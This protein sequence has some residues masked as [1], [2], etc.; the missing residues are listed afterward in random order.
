MIK[1]WSV[2]IIPSGGGAFFIGK[3]YFAK[4]LTLFQVPNVQYTRHD[5]VVTSRIAGN[6]TVKII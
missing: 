6:I 2:L 5:T 1:Y 3:N 4:I